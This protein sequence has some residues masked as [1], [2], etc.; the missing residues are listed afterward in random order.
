MKIPK[1]LWS[2]LIVGLFV[3]T[4]FSVIQ[5]GGTDTA[6][7]H[8]V[9]PTSI[10]PYTTTSNGLTYT[11]EPNGTYL[12]NGHYLRDPPVPYPKVPTIAP[13]G[14]P[15][16]A[17]YSGTR[18]HVGIYHFTR[19][20]PSIVGVSP[21]TTV[22]T[23]TTINANT[24][25]NNETL[26]IVGNVTVSSGYHLYIND[27][28]IIFREPVNTTWDYSILAANNNSLFIQDGSVIEGY[29]A[30]EV[31]WAI[32]EGR[33]IYPNGHD[34]F[35]N[36]TTILDNTTSPSITDAGIFPVVGTAYK[37]PYAAV[38]HYDQPL[39]KQFLGC[40]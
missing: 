39:N 24:A 10:L 32:Q 22:G 31:P 11:V 36:N 8:S 38:F 23:A 9:S 13:D 1:R 17:V 20:A 29:S 18:G 16:G 34:I 12:W 33:G 7:I 21:A 6:S 2:L 40:R 14:L 28:T 37:G 26:T 15:Y 4:A 30:N 27:T 3:L 5:S 25:W 35:I 19:G